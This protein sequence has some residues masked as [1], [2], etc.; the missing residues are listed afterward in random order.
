MVPKL[1]P[2]DTLRAAFDPHDDPARPPK[3]SV[4]EQQVHTHIIPMHGLK[5][6]DALVGYVCYALFTG[7]FLVLKLRRYF[8]RETTKRAS[9]GEKMA[10]KDATHPNITQSDSPEHVG[11]D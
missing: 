10:V 5:I 2:S 4:S 1:K 3:Q 11:Q 9:G 6:W 7:R 8:M